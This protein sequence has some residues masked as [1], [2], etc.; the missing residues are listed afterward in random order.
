ME[1]LDKF[2]THNIKKVE[3]FKENI[4]FIHNTF[5]KIHSLALKLQKL[6]KNIPHEVDSKTGKVEIICGYCNLHCHSNRNVLRKK[7]NPQT[8]K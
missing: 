5:V 1:N 7:N 2:T 3:T 4:T 6:L 8:I